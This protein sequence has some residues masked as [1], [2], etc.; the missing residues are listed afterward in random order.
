MVSN[1]VLNKKTEPYTCLISKSRNSS[2][3][4]ESP[5]FRQPASCQSSGEDHSLW[6]WNQQPQKNLYL[7]FLDLSPKSTRSRLG[8]QQV[9]ESK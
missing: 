5:D 7:S 6:A 4:W 3:E 9:K 8:G 1:G 2:K